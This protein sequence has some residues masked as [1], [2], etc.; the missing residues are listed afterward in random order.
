MNWWSA[1]FGSRFSARAAEV[2]VPVVASTQKPRPRMRSISGK[3]AMSSPTLAPWIQI[4]GPDG[5]FA[6]GSPRRS[7]MRSACSLPR[8]SR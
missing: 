8:F 3:T 5:R 1:P 7:L 6:P 2:T 4:S